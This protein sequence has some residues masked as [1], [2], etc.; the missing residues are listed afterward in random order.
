MS[1]NVLIRA[2][3][4]IRTSMTQWVDSDYHPDGALA[5]KNKPEQVEWVRTLPFQPAPACS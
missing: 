5:L 3:Q 1:D 4:H 2:L